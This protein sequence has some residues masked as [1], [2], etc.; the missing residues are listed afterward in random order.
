MH[1]VSSENLSDFNLQDTKHGDAIF[2]YVDINDPSTKVAALAVVETLKTQD[3][4]EIIKL[5]RH[6]EHYFSPT[7]FATITMKQ[8]LT[9]YVKRK[10]IEMY[11]DDYTKDDPRVHSYVSRLSYEGIKFVANN[12][13]EFAEQ[14]H[15][16][17][18]T[19]KIPKNKFNDKRR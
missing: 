2:V 9:L 15:A 3:D 8:S 18:I 19:M 14:F 11:P 16:G 6:T 4:T 17:R 10:V 5:L 1:V 12:V 7:E 13:K